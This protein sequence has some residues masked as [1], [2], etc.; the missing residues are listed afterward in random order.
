[1][2][3]DC[4]RSHKLTMECILP[5]KDNLGVSI[6]KVILF[7]NAIRSS[8]ESALHL[9]LYAPL[10]KSHNIFWSLFVHSLRYHENHRIR[11][12]GRDL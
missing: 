12:V 11:W 2:V 4:F 3:D 5:G 6:A 8:M 7:G 1:M 10:P 9:C